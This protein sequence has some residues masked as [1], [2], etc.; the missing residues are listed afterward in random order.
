[1]ENVHEYE[2]RT[3]VCGELLD[4]EDLIK[5]AYWIKGAK[6]FVIQNF[7]DGQ[8]VLAGKHQLTP[9]TKEELISIQNEIRPWFN[10]VIVRM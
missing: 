3:T 5:I 4:K 8:N 6:K 1:M 7:R 2:F 10:E 9:Y